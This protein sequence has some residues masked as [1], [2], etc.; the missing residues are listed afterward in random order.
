[1]LEYVFDC[2]GLN[3]IDHVIIDPQFYRPCEVPKLWGDP[4]KTLDKLGWSPKYDFKSLALEMYEI[5]L[6]REMGL[7]DA[8]LWNNGVDDK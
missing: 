4:S 1:F 2:A 8:H 3:I 7:I 6:K 5:D